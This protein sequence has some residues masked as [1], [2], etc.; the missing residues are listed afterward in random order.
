MSENSLRRYVRLQDFIWII[1]F[2]TLI[3]N[4]PTRS[5]WEAMMMVALLA[6]QLLE[7]R[8][9]I[10][11]SS[12][13]RI[14]VFTLKLGLG[15]LLI[16]LSGG[17]KSR[18][19]LVM[20]LPVVSAATEFGL[21]AT[22]L[23]TIC[24]GGAY[25]SQLLFIDWNQYELDS[26]DVAELVV[27]IVMLFMVATL[28]NALA[29]DLRKQ[30][31]ESRRALA[32]LSAANAQIE[33]AAE[34]LRRSDR[35]AALGQLSAG[36]AHELRNPLG[37]IRASAEMISKNI[38]AENE[39]AREVAGFIG[40]EVDRCNS[41]I[42]RFLHFARPLQ[43]KPEK[44]D[45]GQMLDLAI[46]NVE[47]EAPGISIHKSYEAEIPPFEFDAEL[48]ERVFF[49]LI[50]NAVQ[51][52]P[53]GGAVTV[54]TRD[55]GDTAEVFVIDRGSGID[56]KNMDSIFNPFF[57]TKPTGVGLGLAIVAKIID[58]HGGKIAVESE[59]GK[60]TIFRVQLP[61]TVRSATHDLE[62]AT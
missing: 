62:P 17:I 43:I 12:R 44:A 18:Y 24:A 19:W 40:A 11:Q 57:T 39:I 60:G 38:A 53:P 14:V 59:P 58:E 34:T 49:N 13:A 45:L 47:R 56:P 9:P 41:L 37:T 36:L 15:Y 6:A 50:Q 22:Y 2:G 33:Q 29:E 7:D 46:A 10:L 30:T 61:R 20:L 4:S 32:Q 31:R 23:L 8:L 51:A 3:Y 48:M 27:R 54:K 16:G 21:V 5:P 25:L 52:S 28:A 1:L 35:L 26:E 42:T 55:A